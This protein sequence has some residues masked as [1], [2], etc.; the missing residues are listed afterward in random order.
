MLCRLFPKTAEDVVEVVMGDD[1]AAEDTHRSSIAKK[2]KQSLE[3]LDKPSSALLK[4][5]VRNLLRRNFW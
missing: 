1:G 2:M 3:A 5:E 4:F